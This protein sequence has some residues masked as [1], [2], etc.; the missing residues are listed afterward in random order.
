[1]VGEYLEMRII[2]CAAACIGL[3]LLAFIGQVLALAP[4]AY[5][6]NPGHTQFLYAATGAGVGLFLGWVASGRRNP[7]GAPQ[8]PKP[9]ATT[10]KPTER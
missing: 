5:M 9:E 4:G 7:A 1:M 6:S 8:E 10:T 3:G 2:A